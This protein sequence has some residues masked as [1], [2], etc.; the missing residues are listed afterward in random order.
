[1]GACADALAQYA[2]WRLIDVLGG[3][4][5]APSLERVDVVQP[6][7]FALMTSL[8]QAWKAAGVRPDTVIGHSQGEIAAAYVAGALS[9]DDA[10]R[11]V[12]LRSQ[13]LTVLAG[14]GAMASV[15]L[16]P[17][18]VQERLAGLGDR[19]HIAAVNAPSSTVIAGDPAVVAGLLE[20]YEAEGVRVRKIAVD[21]ASHCAHIETI[22]HEVLAALSGLKPRQADI[23]FFSTVTGTLLE[24]TE[25]DGAYW[26]RNLRNMVKFSSSI[27]TLLETG[28]RLFVE[29]S[30]HPVLTM[31]I[32][33]AAVAAEVP[34]TVIGTLR[35][36]RNGRQELLKALGQAHAHGAPVAWETLLPAPRRRVGLPTYPFERT[37][38]WLRGQETM[39]GAQA[40]GL[41]ATGRDLLS[42]GVSLAGDGGHVLTGRISLNSH[43]W[44]A[45]HVVLGTAILPGAAFAELALQAAGNAGCDRVDELTLEL[46]LA[47]AESGAAQLQ[48]LVGPA[49]EQGRR[50]ITISS[51][52]DDGQ[53][54]TPWTQH[55]AG[56][57]SS[58]GP[59]ATAA[60]PFDA[61]SW[62]PPN[63][64]PTDISD[65]Y[66]RF[67]ARGLSYGPAFRGLRAV[68]RAGGY[69]YA[70]AELPEDA[71]ADGHGLHP[72]LLDS[73]LHAMLVA[74]PVDSGEDA[75][76]LLPFAWAGLSLHAT[77]S[78]TLRA[79][80]RQA[81]QAGQHSVTIEL[82]DE[83]GAP[84]ASV[85]QL[86]L[87]PVNPN[88]I[89]APGGQPCPTFGLDWTPPP[90]QA[91]TAQPSR[92]AVLGDGSDG[93]SNDLAALG[94]GVTGYPDLPGLRAC[95]ADG[96][97]APEVVVSVVG[98][99]S[100]GA[101][102][103]GAGSLGAMPDQA[104][105]T[106]QAV[107]GLAREWLTGEHLIAARL[108][109]VTRGAVQAQAGEDIADLPAACA[110]GLIRSAQSENPG[111]FVLVDLDDQPSS[112]AAL[113]AAVAAGEPQIAIRAGQPLVPRLVPAPSA[114]HEAAG[115][116]VADWAAGT[117]LITGG[118]GTLGRLVARHLVTTGGATHLLLTGRQGPAAPGAAELRAELTELGA[119]VNIAAC[120]AAEAGALAALLA[121]I[122]AEHPLSCVIHA[123]G[124]LAD[125]TVET[126]SADQVDAVLRPKADAAW[127]LHELTADAAPAAFIMFSSAA[128]VLG[129]PGQA[130]YAAANGFLD[131]LAA[132]RRARELPA[133]SLAWGLWAQDSG[134]TGQLSTADRG[135]MN[136]NGITPV[137]TDAALAVLDTALGAVTRALIV[138]ARLDRPALRAAAEAGLLPPVLSSLIRVPARQAGQRSL[139][140]GLV[141]LDERAQKRLVLDAVRRQVAAVLGHD[142]PEAVDPSHA[143]RDL[144]FD[145]LMAVELRN[146][147]NTITGLQ[148]PATS[149]FD[150]P[151]TNALAECIRS[152]IAPQIAA[153]SGTPGA[154]AT[155]ATADS[156][157]A[158]LDRLEA[159]LAALP[160][161]DARLASIR[162]KVGALA[163]RWAG[164][165]KEHEEAKAVRE[166]IETASSEE[167]FDFID[168]ELKRTT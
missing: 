118:T 64:E 48:V 88:Q 87:R 123:A 16:A 73:A 98:A 5:G 117:V 119:Q 135:R 10:A 30:P 67:A 101:G 28:H 41:T 152:Q 68:W 20:R 159:S 90:A 52:P 112:R 166:T 138:P 72:A 97:S 110:W 93:L 89:S 121:Q 164:D 26:Y 65:L 124:V 158:E 47:L 146:R 151:T 94:I 107:L 29:V 53:P 25:L 18:V 154:P 145:S 168:R 125:G 161:A 109:V 12:A 114:R 74:D 77:G 60:E 80:M 148:L 120:D 9:L 59:A 140:Q 144:G 21:Y 103:L 69:I 27:G 43:P 85:E 156:V 163:A 42:V 111:R 36:D 11:V 129:A 17:E 23:P 31:G 104:R 61:A 150:F 32:E 58:R 35:R 63:A 7:L 19:V 24:G 133:T 105:A 160:T 4:P 33:Q 102:S 134:L 137:E 75:A 167:I 106:A 128:G 37:Y 95:V 46:P 40:A 100:P 142:S 82:A 78:R 126:L 3:E 51:R 6:V 86:K 1:M 108:V 113:P 127:N 62:P 66:D 91:G 83:T 15:A 50:P 130:N 70:E 122:P 38:Y 136:R 55:A 76:V 147:L 96:A 116:A 13:A 71:T 49:G 56:T 92:W 115:E 22:E 99:G 2:D 44:L 143:F 8:A 54:D 141:G 157:L 39:T 149:V 162:T 57:V 131:G 165:R 139:A 155:A 84:V 79:R 34:A 132:Y 45:D 14:T 153:A 81:G